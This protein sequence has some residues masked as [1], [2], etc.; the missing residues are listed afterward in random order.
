MAPPIIKLDDIRLTFGGT[1]LLDGADL[2]GALMTG[3]VCTDTYFSG[4]RLE[5]ADL[6]NADLTQADFTNARARGATVSAGALD[7]VAIPPLDMADVIIQPMAAPRPPR[8]GPRRGN[9]FLL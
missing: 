2:T 9:F 3:A 4:A 6:R 7:R 5:E 1:P 8:E